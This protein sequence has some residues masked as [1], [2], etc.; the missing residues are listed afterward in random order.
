MIVNLDE[1]L[2]LLKQKIDDLL[3]KQSRVI[4]GIDGMAA[5]GKTTLAKTLSGQ[6]KSKVIHMDDFFLQDHQKTKERLL[7]V[8]GF[9]DYER[10][11]EEVIQPLK[12]NNAFIYHAYDCQSQQMTEKFFEDEY[13]VVI[14]EGAYALRKSF[15]EAY[16]IKI[17]MLIDEDKQ[18]S[19][20]KERNS[21]YLLERFKQEWI[22]RENH[23]IKTCD[24][25][26]SVDYIIKNP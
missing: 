3:K 11:E 13:Q 22:P 8:D 16:D 7:E 25:E 14:I 1:S 24:L 23:Y 26:K 20:I 21:S 19:R 18:E 6:Y 10:F 15:Y 9:I 4:V 2:D 12:S 5:S 17:L